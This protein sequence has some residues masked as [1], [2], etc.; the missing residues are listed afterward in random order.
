MRGKRNASVGRGHELANAL[1][2][3]AR[4]RRL[5]LALTGNEIILFPVR[6]ICCSTIV[7]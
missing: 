4:A 1:Y 7:E 2:F 6:E 3:V 5:I